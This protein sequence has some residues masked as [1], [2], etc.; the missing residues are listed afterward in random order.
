MVNMSAKFDK[1]TCNGVVS[2]SCSQGPRTDARTDRRT[3]THTE[4]Q[5]RC[6]IPTATGCAGIINFAASCTGPFKYMNWILVITLSGAFFITAFTSCRLPLPAAFTR[7]VSDVVRSNWVIF[8]VRKSPGSNTE[9][10]KIEVQNNRQ[11]ECSV[12]WHQQKLSV[13]DG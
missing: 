4:P 13:T 8:L 1:E 3:H 5:Q 9:K 12:S 2:I 6:Y 11:G 7:E 10:I